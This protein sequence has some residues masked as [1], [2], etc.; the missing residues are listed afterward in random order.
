M[1]ICGYLSSFEN[2]FSILSFFLLEYILFYVIKM[3]FQV[4]FPAFCSIQLEVPF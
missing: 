1:F 2:F 4:F 3:Y